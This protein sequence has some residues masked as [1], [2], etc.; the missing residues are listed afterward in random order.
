M[1]NIKYIVNYKIMI[2]YYISEANKENTA[3]LLGLAVY[4][5]I[6]SMP[7]K[8]RYSFNVSTNN[9]ISFLIPESISSTVMDLR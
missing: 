9:E 2:D 7:Y 1:A 6:Y 4:L 3:N 5:D 8:E